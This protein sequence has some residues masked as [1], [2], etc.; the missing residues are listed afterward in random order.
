MIPLL[1]SSIQLVA[2]CLAV[3]SLSACLPVQYVRYPGVE[4]IVVDAQHRT[5]LKAAVTLK[6]LLGNNPLPESSTST[7]TTGMFRLAPNES[8]GLWVIPAT[9]ASFSCTLTIHVLGYN[10][11]SKSF[12]T[13]SFGPAVTQLGVIMMER[14]N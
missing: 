2:A 6:P 14:N 10:E 9:P 3:L 1:R 8:F 11:V 13:S 12:S 4:G 7:D 5:P